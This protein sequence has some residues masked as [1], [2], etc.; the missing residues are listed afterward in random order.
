MLFDRTHL[1]FSLTHEIPDKKK[2]DFGLKSLRNKIILPVVLVALVGVAIMASLVFL[3]V[4]DRLTANVETLATNKVEKLV[5]STD[6]QLVQWRDQVEMLSLMDFVRAG[7]F[8]QLQVFVRKTNVFEDFD[9]LI[10]TDLKGDFRGTNRTKGNM[11]EE[12][13]YET[14]MSGEIVITDPMPSQDGKRTEIFIAAPVHDDYGQVTGLIGGLVE[15]SKLTETINTEKIG[16][17]G[18]AF[19]TTKDGLV[20]AHKQEDLRLA[21]NIL[22]GKPEGFTAVANRM[23]GGESAVEKYKLDGEEKI[24]AY[25]PVSLTGW[26]VAMTATYQEVISDIFVLGRTMTLIGV[27]IVVLLAIIVFIVV[28]RSVKPLAKMTQLTEAIAKGDLNVHVDVK[29]KDEIGVLADN[30]NLMIESM[31]GLI[32]D[33]SGMSEKVLTTSELMMDSTSE[34]SRVSEQVA[35][36]ISEVAR[37]ATE[38]SESTQQSSEMV[39]NLIEGIGRIAANAGE[40]ESMSDQARERVDVGFETIS[41][42]KNKM[43]MNKQATEQVGV[44]VNALSEKSDKIGQIADVISSI[45]GQT[46]LLALNAS[47]EAARAGEHGRGFAVVADEVR[48]LAEESGSAAQGIGELLLDIRKGIEDAVQEM[49]KVKTIVEDQEQAVDTT[50]QA[51]DDILKAV[52]AVMENTNEMTKESGELTAF[53]YV[54]GENIENIASIT[55]QNAA[56]TEEVSA[57]TEEQTAS[58]QQIASSAAE[59]ADLATELQTSLQRFRVDDSKGVTKTQSFKPDSPVAN[60]WEKEVEKNVEKN[61]NEVADNTESADLSYMAQDTSNDSLQS[62]FEEADSLPEG[63]FYVDESQSENSDQG[64]SAEEAWDWDE[65]QPQD[66][67][68]VTD[69]ENTEI[70][71]VDQ[72][73]DKAPQEDDDT[74]ENKHNA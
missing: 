74:E 63:V 24:I 38:Q 43:E 45:A 58:I 71:Q 3:Q 66:F 54:V 33:V 62:Q 15:L 73:E 32:R 34:A 25:K 9:A 68:K 4:S 26:P 69:D 60:D 47:I 14:V 22:E 35:E 11:A 29:T 48:K 70:G 2:G 18:F 44:K 30:F 23:V 42:Q 1:I 13:Y 7:N 6:S 61:V 20:M 17:T 46:N 21:D 5:S 40:S 59:L 28:N 64:E 37:G 72:E 56:G 53:S 52:K 19:M 36:T 8:N 39:Q 50:A 12:A 65:P 10:M 27:G 55:E 41:A 49:S 57:S 16:E 31:R 67:D 51:F